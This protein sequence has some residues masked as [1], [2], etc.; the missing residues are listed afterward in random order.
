M[1]NS[2]GKIVRNAIELG[3]WVTRSV[4][5]SRGSSDGRDGWWVV[6]Q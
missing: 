2:G 3:V 1:G 4:V 6:D 5:R